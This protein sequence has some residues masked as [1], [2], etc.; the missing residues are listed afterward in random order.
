MGITDETICAANID[1]NDPHESPIAP[2]SAARPQDSD[3]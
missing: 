3:G 1:E 2:R